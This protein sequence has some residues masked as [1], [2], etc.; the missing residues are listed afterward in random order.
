MTKVLVFQHY[1]DKG[2]QDK[3]QTNKYKSLDNLKIDKQN[4]LILE[5]CLSSIKKWADLNNYTYELNTTK[6]NL[7]TI[8]DCDDYIYSMYKYKILLE[9]AKLKKYDY[10]IY[11]DNDMY[12]L[13]NKPF[14]LHSWALTTTFFPPEN[15]WIQKYIN[16]LARF[17]CSSVMCMDN[18]TLLNFSKWLLD[19]IEG[20]ILEPIFIDTK[21][22]DYRISSSHEFLLSLYCETVQQP[23]H[24]P[25]EW[26]SCPRRYVDWDNNPILLHIDSYD[27]GKHLLDFVPK[28]IQKKI[29]YE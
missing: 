23:N 22:A 13:E 19:R 4:S 11:L 18:N 21:K 8:I 12:M 10:Y 5:K 28:N 15:I 29:L 26:H 20:R 6:P 16:P 14:P 7:S 3:G 24:L 25:I 9:L 17:W 1:I 2:Y 27:K